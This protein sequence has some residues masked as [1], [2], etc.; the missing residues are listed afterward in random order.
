[1]APNSDKNIAL[2]MLIILRRRRRRRREQKL[3]VRFWI[4]RIMQ[5]GAYQN[6]IQ[7]LALEGKKCTRTILEWRKPHLITTT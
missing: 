3:W 6:L 4:Q 7:E 2:A 5:Q 1:M